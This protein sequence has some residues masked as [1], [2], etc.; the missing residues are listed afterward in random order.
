MRKVD[1]PMAG[2]SADSAEE[3]KN[4]TP[5]VFEVKLHKF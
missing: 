2:A 5:K 3:M 1:P 4:A